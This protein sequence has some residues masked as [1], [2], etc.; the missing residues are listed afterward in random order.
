MAVS[1]WTAVILI[2]AVLALWFG[3][4]DYRTLIRP[5]ESQLCGNSAGNGP[6]QDDWI[7]PRL[8]AIKYFEKPALQYWA[9]AAAYT[10]FGE[11]HWTARLWPAIT[12][13]GGILLA[14]FLGTRLWGLRAGIV[15]GAMLGGTLIYNFMG[16]I[17]TLDMS[18]T[19]F[20]Q[21]AL[22]GFILTQQA[23]TS[24]ASRHWIWLAWGALGLAMLSKG[25]VALVLTGMT[26]VLYSL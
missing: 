22:T 2:A 11:H 26:V 17:V 19:F 1:T 5:D 21:L 24:R 18:L 16:H 12:G 4:L 9:T 14:A 20:L 10:V 13:F 7:T 25:L 8:N 3:T 15:A 23:E 6:Q